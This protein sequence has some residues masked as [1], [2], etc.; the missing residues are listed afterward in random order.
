M[1][2]EWTAFFDTA[3]GGDWTTAKPLVRA[4]A[5]EFVAK[6][7]IGDRELARKALI[8]ALS[9]DK[10]TEKELVGILAALAQSWE[11]NSF[12]GNSF[13]QRILASLEDGDLTSREIAETAAEWTARRT[14][15]D[16]LK[17]II[18]SSADGHL[19]T[20]EIEQS[21]VDWLKRRGKTGLAQ[22]V[23]Q[24]LDAPQSLN[25]RSLVLMATAYLVSQGTLTQ[26]GSTID[27]QRSNLISA[28]NQLGDSGLIEIIQALV[29]GDDVK[30]LILVLKDLGINADEA[31]P[32]AILSGRLHD[33]LRE[34]LVKS[35]ARNIDGLK[36]GQPG[37]L[38]D[39]IIGV[40]R[41]TV[42]I[43][44]AQ[45]ERQE[46]GMGQNEYKIYVR[47]RKLV[48]AAKL[49]VA[50]G[51]L[52]PTDA[53]AQPHVFAAAALKPETEIGTL[54]PQDKW[55]LLLDCLLKFKNVE[56][57]SHGSVPANQELLASGIILL[58]VHKRIKSNA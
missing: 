39:A 12:F 2:Q 22:Q 37:D 44:I 55:P 42:Q 54:A 58:E 50:G 11:N 1:S 7:L 16:T 49:A 19:S 52:V 4:K 6:W 38:A 46:L 43:V 21:I 17:Q 13:V 32:K 26:A 10:L 15:N 28:F 30:A 41:G 53:M 48:Y 56:F 29:A 36:D 5:H 24:V 45:D 18:R 9:D 34:L 51:P 25:L 47:V 31:L 57:G 40:F 14:T 3:V 27:K 20:N 33:V 23:Q 35:L 8:S